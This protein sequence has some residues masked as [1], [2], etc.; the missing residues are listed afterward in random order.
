MDLV[1]KRQMILSLSVLALF[2]YNATT[3]TTTRKKKEL[4]KRK[5][6]HLS[7]WRLEL[8][9]QS[10]RMMFTSRKIIYYKNG[11]RNKNNQ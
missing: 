4:K 3:T 1:K 6:M 10:P 5:T 2:L 8:E 7:P 11:K 9:S